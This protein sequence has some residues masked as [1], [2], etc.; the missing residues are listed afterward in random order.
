ML[1]TERQLE[2]ELTRE[3]AGRSGAANMTIDASLLA[4]AARA[5]RSFVR[6]YRFDPPCLSLGRNEPAAAQYDRAAIARLG[7]DVV[8]RPTGGGAVWH[9]H[10]VTYAVAA[11]IATFGGLRAAYHAIHARLAAALQTLGVATALAPDRPTARPPDRRGSCFATPVGGEVLVGGRKL[12]GSAQVREGRAFLQHG[13][14]LLAGSQEMIAAV[15]REP[16]AASAATTLS[17]ELRRQVTW[18]EVADAVVRAWGDELTPAALYR[19]LP[20]ST[21]L[22]ADPFWTWRR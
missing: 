7:L 9:E 16:Q 1:L 18:D 17:K 4:E 6:L 20:P 15:S 8:R 21:A 14:I 11:S 19:R 3:P 2:W 13:S 12:I 22:F 10:E 5:G